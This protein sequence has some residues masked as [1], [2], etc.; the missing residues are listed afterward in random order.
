MTYPAI[1]SLVDDFANALGAIE[2]SGISLKAFA[3]SFK[4]VAT[5]TPNPKAAP[6]I[7]APA[8]TPLPFSQLITLMAGRLAEISENL[9]IDQSIV[10]D[11]WGKAIY[12]SKNE[13][14]MRF[15]EAMGPEFVKDHQPH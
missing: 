4:N 2:E 11:M 9:Q 1:Q 10:T 12:E 5:L 3:R 8:I 6:Y 15:K 7:A 14:L 13:T